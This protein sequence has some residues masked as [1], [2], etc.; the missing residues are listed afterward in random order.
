MTELSLAELEAAASAYEERLV[1]ALFQAWAE[2]VSEAAQ[3]GDGQRVLD[4]ACGTGVLAREMAKRVGPGGSVFGLDLNPGMLAIAKKIA[5]GITWRQGEAGSLPF[6]DGSFD[7]AASQFGFMFFPDHVAALREMARV[8]APS[9]RI[10][11]AV[12]DGLGENQAYAKLADVYE[13]QV[14]KSTGDALRMPFS[15]G[16]KGALLALFAA[17]GM[18]AAQATTESR[19]ARFSSIRDLVL[20][21]VEGWFPLAQIQLDDA[22]IEAVVDQAESALAN[23]LVEG[24]GLAFPV[25]AHILTAR[26]A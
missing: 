5:P 20:A 8:L 21:D 24:G 7:V 22:T 19:M 4:V 11:V 6:D 15:L 14:G 16:D 2:V 26:K 10:A 25:Q 18:E 3:V 1:P 9:G 13:D 23:F 17:A 12:F